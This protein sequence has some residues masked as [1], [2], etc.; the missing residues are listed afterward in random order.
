MNNGLPSGKIEICELTNLIENGERNGNMTNCCLS[1]SESRL[2]QNIRRHL[3]QQK[4]L[5]VTSLKSGKSW[6]E[7]V[8]ERTLS[9]DTTASG[10]N[11]AL[12]ASAEEY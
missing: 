6:R 7:Y 8:A 10:G 4:G 5:I 3:S 9:I 1:F 2:K 11:A 12:L